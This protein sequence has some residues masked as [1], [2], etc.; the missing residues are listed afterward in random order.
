MT[1]VLDCYACMTSKPCAEHDAP[2]PL[3]SVIV[4]P[5]EGGLIFLGR[6]SLSYWTPDRGGGNLAAFLKAYGSHRLRLSLEVEGK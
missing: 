2:A 3:V 5:D 6:G 4:E 1:E